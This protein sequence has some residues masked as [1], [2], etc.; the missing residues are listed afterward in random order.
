MG[1]KALF[2]LAGVFDFDLDVIILVS[3]CSYCVEIMSD[4]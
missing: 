3:S 4:I 2:Q 1:V